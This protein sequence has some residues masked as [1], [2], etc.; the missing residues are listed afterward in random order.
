MTPKNSL[1]R[2]Q[3]R[4][5]SNV[6]SCSIVDIRCCG[7]SWLFQLIGHFPQRFLFILS[8]M[9]LIHMSINP[10]K[11]GVTLV[12]FGV[13]YR[14]FKTF[15]T[16]I[17]GFSLL[18]YSLFCSFSPYLSFYCFFYSLFCF[19][20]L[21]ILFFALFFALFLFSLLYSFSSLV[22]SPPFSFVVFL[23]VVFLVVVFL[24]V[25]RARA[26]SSS[27]LELERLPCRCRLGYG[28]GYSEDS[29]Y[30]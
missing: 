11:F 13:R 20:S 4:S 9:S 18:F 2:V 16:E 19:F 7:W 14:R 3:L 26:S 25:V 21:F 28:Y 22:C 30:G 17:L 29:G 23:V 8:H 12:R 6:R 24:V 1:E 5:F 27:S 10:S 15:K